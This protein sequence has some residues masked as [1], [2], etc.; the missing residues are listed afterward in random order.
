MCDILKMAGRG[1]KRSEISDS[2]ILVTHIMSTFALVM[3]KVILGSFGAVVLKWA[4]SQ[5]RLVVE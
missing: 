3:F 2:R 4:V 1:P 5:K